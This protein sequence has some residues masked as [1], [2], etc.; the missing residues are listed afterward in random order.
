[1]NLSQLLAHLAK[2]PQDAQKLCDDFRLSAEGD[3]LIGISSAGEKKDWAR[4][5][6]YARALLDTARENA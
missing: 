4:V 5:S 2:R 3:I 1:M 6:D